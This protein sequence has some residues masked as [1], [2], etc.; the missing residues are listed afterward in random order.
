[1]AAELAFFEDLDV[2]IGLRR[3]PKKNPKNQSCSA[4]SLQG[5]APSTSDLL[6]R[7]YLCLTPEMKSLDITV[8]F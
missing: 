6:A 1:M 8:Y 5:D 2:A 4:K 3:Q 7:C